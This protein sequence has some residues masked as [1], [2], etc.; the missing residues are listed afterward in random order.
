MYKKLILILILI[1]IYILYKSNI[2]TFSNKILN[3]NT[4]YDHLYIKKYDR[5]KVEK[6]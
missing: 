1:I 6:K 4:S 2:E 3:T 5:K